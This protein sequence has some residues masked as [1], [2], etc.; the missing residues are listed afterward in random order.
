MND[1]GRN[2][3]KYNNDGAK[4]GMALAAGAGTVANGTASAAT[5]A[6]N[7]IQG[8]GATGYTTGFQGAT[9]SI[10]GSFN[11]IAGKDGVVFDGVANS[12][13]G[14]ANRTENANGAL[15]FGAGNK[16]TNSYREVSAGSTPFVANAADALTKAITTGDNTDMIGVLGGMVKES[17][18]A[19]LAIGGANTANYALLS[20]VVGVGNTLTGTSNTPSEYNMLDGFANTAENV[21]H[22]SVSGKR[23]TRVRHRLQQ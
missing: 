3:G 6:F 17:G 20:K 5:G 15:I 12:L 4:G 21:Q 10:Y 8:N 2:A 22:V 9:S 23:S 14:V 18:G 19:V 11:T 7:Q 1:L 16:V 13:V